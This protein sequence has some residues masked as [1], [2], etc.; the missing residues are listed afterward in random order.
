MSIEKGDFMLPETKISVD[1]LRCELEDLIGVDWGS[2]WAGPPQGGSEEF[3]DWCDRYGWR[4]LTV[5]GDPEIVTRHGNNLEFRTR[6]FWSP[7]VSVDASLWRVHTASPE[8]KGQVIPV[9]VRPWEEYLGMISDVLGEP[10]DVGSLEDGSFPVPPN[11]K[12]WRVP[13]YPP[14]GGN[15]R[16]AYWGSFGGR[17][18]GPITVL[19]QSVSMYTWQAEGGGGS[20]IFLSLKSPSLGEMNG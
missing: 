9:G 11:E 2:V 12:W 14:K 16:V 7:V 1:S 4:S 5:E 19:T 18:Q 6:G 10:T 15:Y 8:E 20:G 17:P 3:R 13:E